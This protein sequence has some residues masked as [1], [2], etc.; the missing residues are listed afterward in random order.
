MDEKCGMPSN[1]MSC[2]DRGSHYDIRRIRTAGSEFIR[3]LLL[4]PEISH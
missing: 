4:A 1:D 2:T 3:S